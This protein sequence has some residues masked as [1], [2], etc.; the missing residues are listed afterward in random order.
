MGKELID[1]SEDKFNIS[2]VVLIYWRIIGY[3]NHLG[4]AQSCG[5]ICSEREIS[6]CQSLFH[7]VS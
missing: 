7:Q 5:D 1:L 4:A 6:F 2:P 3:P